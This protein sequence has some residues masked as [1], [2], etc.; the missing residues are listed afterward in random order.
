MPD[1]ATGT[2]AGPQA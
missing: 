1:N 2:D